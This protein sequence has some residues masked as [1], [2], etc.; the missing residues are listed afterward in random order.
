MRRREWRQPIKQNHLEGRK[1]IQED[2]RLV[3]DARENVGDPSN[4]RRKRRSPDWYTGY[5]DMM[6]KMVETEPSSFEEV[7]EKAIWFAAMVEEYESI[8]KNTVCE[9]FPRSTDR[10]MVGS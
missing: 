1:R 6:K 9:V 10:S 4:Q 7:V 2:E 8:A 5:M 3:Q